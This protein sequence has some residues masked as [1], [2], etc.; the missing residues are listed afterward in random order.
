MSERNHRAQKS[1]VFQRSARTHQVRRNNGL[2]MPRRERVR[3]AQNECHA[4]RHRNH[5]RRQFLL[6]QKPG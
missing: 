6:M 5:P 3:G 2:A 1:G 4:Q